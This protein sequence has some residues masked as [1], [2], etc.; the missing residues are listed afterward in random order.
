V[1]GL[2]I[3]HRLSKLPKPPFPALGW[4]FP[5]PGRAALRTPAGWLVLG[6]RPPNPGFWLQKE[7]P[8]G[9][10][11]TPLERALAARAV[12]EVTALRQE[13]LDRV[14]ILEFSGRGGFV[15]K[16][17]VRLIFELTG[18]NA[19][20]LLT[21]PEG[22]ILALDRPVP[23]RLNRYRE[24]LPGRPYRPPPP[25]QKRD[26]RTL[27]PADLAPLAGKPLKRIV[28][29]VDGLG[30]RAVGFLAQRAGLDPDRPLTP[31]D[32]PRL[33]RAL[34][35]LLE[36][37]EVL[38][39]AEPAGPDLEAL[40]RPLLA[41]LEKEARA[42]VRRIADHQ[43][44]LARRDRARERKRTAEL[45]LAYAHRVPRGA[46]EV[47]L[48]D[49]ESG[50]PVRI[51]LDPE[52]TPVENAE[53]LFQAARKDEAA[54]EKAARLLVRTRANLERVRAEIEALKAASPEELRRR[55]K[56]Q[57]AAPPRVGLRFRSPGGLEA[58][59]G[60]NARENEALLRLARPDDLWFHVQGLPGSHVVLRTGGKPAPLPDLL[61]AAR[62]AA[63]H[64]RA[65]GERNAPVDY[66][67]RKY[68]RK[69]RK[70]P[71]GTV[72]YSQAK[73]LFVD[74]SLPENVDAV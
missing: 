47:E 42:L 53:A 20:L 30:P 49:F 40:R 45:L 38:A 51:P 24:L 6:Y 56:A 48:P 17:P 73:T 16:P 41:A 5:E 39:R 66:T 63:Y 55:L 57:K 8:K 71:P 52:K 25:Y 62:L 21:D 69:V 1:E 67:R 12:G 19:N 35:A 4:T 70:A 2:L 22:R 43:R 28:A 36:D 59:V 64:S 58:W 14:L 32:L 23:A 26:P 9:P 13:K 72:T 37:P 65:R 61:F 46:K 27:G 50:R 15:S 68:V 54:A 7:V 44:N 18:R 33:H 3:A 29:L 10:P 11:S 31:D 74:A 60:R 34:Q